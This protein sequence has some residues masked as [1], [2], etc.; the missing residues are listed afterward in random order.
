MES[1]I[2]QKLTALSPAHLQIINESHM[3]AGPATNSHFKLVVVSEEFL[4]LSK[5]AR[6]QK[7]YSLLSNELECELHALSMFLHTQGEWEKQQ[8]VPESPKC[9]GANK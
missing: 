8:S 6:H 3:H 4:N 2:K 5:V 1:V 7:I 9:Q